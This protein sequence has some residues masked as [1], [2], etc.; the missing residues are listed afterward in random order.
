MAYAERRRSKLTRHLKQV[1]SARVTRHRANMAACCFAGDVIARFDAS[2]GVAYMVI[3]HVTH[4]ES[5]FTTVQAFHLHDWKETV[6]RLVSKTIRFCDNAHRC[7]G[8]HVSVT[9][10]KMLG[11]LRTVQAFARSGV[12]NIR[13]FT[14]AVADQNGD[15]RRVRLAQVLSVCRPD[16]GTASKSGVAARVVSDDRLVLSGQLHFARARMSEAAERRAR[17]WYNFGGDD[18]ILARMWT[19]FVSG[20]ESHEDVACDCE[21]VDAYYVFF[22]T[23]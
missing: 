3:D 2:E 15:A 5:K 8:W 11:M 13:E 19:H 16:A 23:H 1:G 14:D 9:A 12:F 6:P 7:S 20:R 4:V 21:A 10:T 18:F 22:Y 17:E